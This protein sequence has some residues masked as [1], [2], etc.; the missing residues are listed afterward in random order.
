MKYKIVKENTVIDIIESP[1]WL[2]AYNNMLVMCDAKEATGILSSDGS[3][4]YHMNGMDDLD[5][6][7]EDTLII[8][9]TDEEADE[10]KK[11]TDLGGTVSNENEIIKDVPEAEVVYVDADLE[12]IR[13]FV[14]D[15]MSKI[16]GSKIEHGV[17]VDLPSGKTKHFALTLEDQINL[18]SLQNQIDSGVT[19]I[20]Y[21]AD[22]ELCMY[23]SAEDIRAIIREANLFRTEQIIYFNSLKN[24]IN[25][26]KTKEEILSVNYGDSIPEEYRSEVMKNA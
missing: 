22:D 5:M 19:S 3:I 17:D 26:M 2:K 1:I 16:C 10:I 9:I 23:Y 24:W 14:I 11:I 21:H 7:D 18:I 12:E 25:S 20:P 4:S 8:Q 13:N 15:S 6:Y